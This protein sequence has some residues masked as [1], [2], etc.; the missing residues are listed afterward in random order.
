MSTQSFSIGDIFLPGLQTNERWSYGNLGLIVIGGD[1]GDIE[2]AS[3]T[4]EHVDGEDGVMLHDVDFLTCMDLSEFTDEMLTEE[5]DQVVRES[6]ASI[7]EETFAQSRA[8]YKRK[9]G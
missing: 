2:A 6:Y 4:N 1:R 5:A 3:A 8:A 9:H 7:Q